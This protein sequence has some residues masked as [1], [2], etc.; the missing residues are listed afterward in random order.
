MQSLKVKP[1]LMTKFY[2][3]DIR[4]ISTEKDENVEDL[5]DDVEGKG[6]DNMKV[7]L[8][9]GKEKR[10]EGDKEKER[11]PEPITER[12]GKEEPEG[13]T[14]TRPMGVQT[15]KR[16][17]RGAASMSN[18]PKITEYMIRNMEKG[19]KR[20]YPERRNKGVEMTTETADKTEV[21]TEHTIPPENETEKREQIGE[22]RGLRPASQE[23]RTEWRAASEEASKSTTA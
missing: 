22:A 5:E 9:T 17:E 7:H 14:R 4:T 18:S 2:I 8:R 21:A 3:D 16:R 15:P 23:V 10:S 19:E 12:D 13:M 11:E 6:R 1:G 20:D